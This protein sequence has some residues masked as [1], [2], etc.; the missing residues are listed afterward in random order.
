MNCGGCRTASPVFVAREILCRFGHV[1]VQVCRPWG[2]KVFPTS[3][4]L[5]CPYLVRLAGKIE[6]MGG[7]HEL[8]EYITS[9]GLVH[10]WREYNIAHQVIRL[11]LGARENAFMRRFRARIFRDVM[12]GGVG[13]IRVGDGVNVKCLHLQTASLI[14]TGHHPASEWLRSKGLCGDCGGDLCGA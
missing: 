8:E 5:V 7:V 9:R 6:S 3:F 10:E 2:R 14:G 13:G 4:W 1:R 11:K 12:R